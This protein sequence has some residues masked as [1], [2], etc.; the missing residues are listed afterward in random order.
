M[1]KFHALVWVQV[2]LAHRTLKISFVFT[3]ASQKFAMQKAAMSDVG[4]DGPVT[5]SIC[6]IC[7]SCV[8]LKGFL[9]R[10][11]GFEGPE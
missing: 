9:V 8:K 2:N 11:C 5:F 3:M 4:F 6:P 7:V 10:P 1:E